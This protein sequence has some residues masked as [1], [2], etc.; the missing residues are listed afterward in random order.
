[1]KIPILKEKDFEQLI[2]Q[3]TGIDN[4]SFEKAFYSNVDERK[5]RV[6]IP[7]EDDY[8]INWSKIS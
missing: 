1:M 4:F 3:R 8:D 6:I 7:N 2:K 5:G